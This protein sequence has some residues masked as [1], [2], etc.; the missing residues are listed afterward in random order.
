MS[1]HLLTHAD[2]Q[3]WHVSDH[4]FCN[5]AIFKIALRCSQCRGCCKK[6]LN[7]SWAETS[8]IFEVKPFGPLAVQVA[9]WRKLHTAVRRTACS[10][11]SWIWGQLP[12]C[13]TLL[14]PGLS[15]SHAGSP[16]LTLGLDDCAFCFESDRE[17]CVIAL[18]NT[19]MLDL[20]RSYRPGRQMNKKVQNAVRCIKYLGV[21]EAL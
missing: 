16:A 12:G 4:V 9:K 11:N 3:K 14:L 18:C 19:L 20:C 15:F 5:S 6:L 13:F 2:P 8:P 21:M 10:R 1:I 7:A 17:G